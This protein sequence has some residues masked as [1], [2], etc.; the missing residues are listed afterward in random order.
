MSRLLYIYCTYAMYLIMFLHVHFWFTNYFFLQV[1]STYMYSEKQL[2]HFSPTVVIIPTLKVLVIIAL[3]QKYHEKR[4][5]FGNK[6]K[7]TNFNCIMIIPFHYYWCMEFHYFNIHLNI[8]SQKCWGATL[9]KEMTVNVYMMIW[10]RCRFAKIIIMEWGGGGPSSW[11]YNPTTTYCK[12]ITF[13]CV[14]HL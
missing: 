3:F 6:K 14:F 5:N 9:L 1:Q 13:D 12:W 10:E 7:P 8:L 2:F 11:C 4:I